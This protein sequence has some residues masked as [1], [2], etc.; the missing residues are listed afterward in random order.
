[1]YAGIE[2]QGIARSAQCQLKLL[3]TLCN[4]KLQR[5]SWKARWVVKRERL[6][7]QMYE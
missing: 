1:M 4:Q 2:V 7:L 6:S 5:Q 3:F